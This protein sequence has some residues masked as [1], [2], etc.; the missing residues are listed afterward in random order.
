VPPS[1]GRSNPLRR[2]GEAVTRSLRWFKAAAWWVHVLATFAAVVVVVVVAVA[3][4]AFL[5]VDYVR[6]HEPLASEDPV[7]SE[8]SAKERAELARRFAPIIRYDTRE[9]FVPIP[10]SAYVTRV[11]LK[12]QEGRFVRLVRP[13]LGRD[14]L[15]SVEGSCLRSRGCLFF[16]D[17]RGVEPDPPKRSQ[18][19]YDRIENQLFREGARPTVY[20]HVTRYDD[21]G[22]YAVQYWFLY[23]FNFRLNEHES[24]WEQITVRLDADKNPVDV[25]ISA[26]EGGDR[27]DWDDVDRDGDHPIVYPALGSHANYFEPGKHPVRVGCRRVIGSIQRCLKGRKVLVDLADGAGRALAPDDYELA[28]LEGPTFIGSYGTGNYVVLTRQ[29][30]VLSDPR[31][32]ALWADPLRPLR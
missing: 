24:D 5:Y 4:L 18:L 14:D 1:A 27:R 20:A 19:A 29:P 26:H 16:L 17:I 10:V 28:E 8:P 30:S 32:R 7:Q 6:E 3:T 9:L 12:E 13:S 23:F 22:D 25:F 11:Q 31:M 21:T 15:P 2:V